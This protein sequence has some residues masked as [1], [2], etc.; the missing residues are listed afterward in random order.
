M[1]KLEEKI[2]Q[3]G[4]S[5]IDAINLSAKEESEALK[6]RLIEEA[7]ADLEVQLHKAQQKAKA[8]V[9]QAK[10][11]GMRALRDE[12]AISKQQLIES[13]FVELKAELKHLNKEDYFNYVVRSIQNQAIDKTEEIQVSKKEY[14]MYQSILTT[15]KGD[16]VEAD[17][18]NQKLGKDYQLK[19]SNKPAQ[20][21]SGFMLVGKL[22]DLNFSL[23]NL[24]ESLTKKYEKTIYEA[25]N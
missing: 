1:S 23:E 3:K 18:L 17:L 12:V 9:E 7:K 5:I 13:I 11:E 8:Q 4:Q 24:L 22:Y 14:A 20:I 19:L 15:K 2:I 25:L 16:L 21:E 6:N 10:Q